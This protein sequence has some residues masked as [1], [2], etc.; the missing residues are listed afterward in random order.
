MIKT[1][2]IIPTCQ[3]QILSTQPL[4]KMTKEYLT[5]NEGLLLSSNPALSDS[6][7]CPFIPSTHNPGVKQYISPKGVYNQVGKISILTH[8]KI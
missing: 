4:S 8:K 2:I 5:Q 6:K 1:N 3:A 7:L